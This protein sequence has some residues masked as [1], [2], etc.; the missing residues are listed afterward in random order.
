[1]GKQVRAINGTGKKKLLGKHD[2]G[3]D[4]GRGGER[5]ERVGRGGEG[6]GGEGRGGEGRGGEGR[7]G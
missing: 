2:Q 7:V 5:Q 6:R 4:K 1:M 3:P